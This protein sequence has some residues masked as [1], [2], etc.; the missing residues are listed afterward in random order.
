VTPQES[1]SPSAPGTSSA[2]GPAA[3]ELVPGGGVGARLRALDPNVRGM[4]WVSFVADLSSE[5]VYPLFPIFITTILG[6]PVAVLGLIEGVAEGTATVLR[7]P[8]GVLS[9]RL[10]RRRPFVFAGY[11]L[12]G[13]G[14]LLIAVAGVWGVALAGRV[15]DRTGKGIRTAPRDALLG[16]SVAPGQ[17]GLAFGLHRT[18]DTMG[19]AVGPLIALAGLELGLPFRWVLGLAAVPGLLSVVVIWAAVRERPQAPE[20]AAFRLRLP[21]SPAF[22]WLLAGSL[23]FGVGNSTDMFILLKAKDVGLGASGVILVYVLYNLVYAAASLPLG[24]LSDRIGQF[25]L[26]IAGYVVFAAVYLGFAVTGS[27]AGVAAL[28]AFYGLYIAATEGT[29][30]ALI[31]RATPLRERASAIGLQ[32]TLSGVATLLASSV[33][34]VLWSAAGPWATF[35]FGAVCALAAAVLMM[36]GRGAVRRSLAAA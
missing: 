11:G 1:G 4:G 19:A 23:V 14:K 31:S 33:G 15:I 21:A 2:S 26:V 10:G 30:K 3:N 36:L 18:M 28:F 7:Y 25:P 20:P 12:S 24:G 27:I 16:A 17:H 6:A 22:R 5:I 29:S 35:A 9:D 32:A 8:F 34:G 13:L